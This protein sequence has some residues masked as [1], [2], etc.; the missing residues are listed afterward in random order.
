[1]PRRLKSEVFFLVRAVTLHM[2]IKLLKIILHWCLWHVIDDKTF[3][4]INIWIGDL[5]VIQALKT[6]F[7]YLKREHFT[8]SICNLHPKELLNLWRECCLGFNIWPGEGWDGGISYNGGCL[9]VWNK[10]NCG[11]MGKWILFSRQNQKEHSLINIW[12]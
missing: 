7:I 2:M 1:M 8:I 12:A 11:E 4:G 5:L 9:V 6:N 10:R 3:H